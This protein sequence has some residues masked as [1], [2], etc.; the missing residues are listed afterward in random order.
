MVLV[1]LD[2]M[3]G[4]AHVG[5]LNGSET[6]SKVNRE[7]AVQLHS[8]QVFR[9]L[10]SVFD[11]DWCSSR[12]LYLPLVVALALSTSQI[13]RKPEFRLTH[14]PNLNWIPQLHRLQLYEN[15]QLS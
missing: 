5:S 9:Y 13:P 10:K 15:P 8:D 3:G 4:Y 2:G 1:W 7:L 14:F 12:P 6:A 11:W